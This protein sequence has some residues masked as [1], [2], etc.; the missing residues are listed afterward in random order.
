ML[1]KEFSAFCFDDIDLWIHGGAPPYVPK[2]YCQT[3]ALEGILAFVPSLRDLDKPAPAPGRFLLY[4]YSV[5]HSVGNTQWKNR[6][7]SCPRVKRGQKPYDNMSKSY[8]GM[9]PRAMIAPENVGLGG[10]TSNPPHL[11]LPTSP[12]G[13]YYGHAYIRCFSIL[14]A[15]VAMDAV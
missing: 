10:I 3:T 4:G 5:V 2:R 14:L 11:L 15:G 1:T 13:V 12:A 9:G 6:G 8:A 7:G